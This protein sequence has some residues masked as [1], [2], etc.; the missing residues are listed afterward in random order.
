VA[1][2]TFPDAGDIQ[3]APSTH[4]PHVHTPD[5]PPPQVTPRADSQLGH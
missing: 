2:K 3:D 1:A 4:E 5:T